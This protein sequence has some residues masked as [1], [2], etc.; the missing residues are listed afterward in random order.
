MVKSN[1][2][3]PAFAWASSIETT[4]W[5][6]PTRRLEEPALSAENFTA[7][8]PPGVSSSLIVPW[9]VTVPLLE[10]TEPEPSPEPVVVQY[11]IA[12]AASASAATTPRTAIVRFLFSTSVNTEQLLLSRFRLERGAPCEGDGEDGLGS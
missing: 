9:S 2:L 5:T 7:E 1:A 11:A 6:L 10:A 12:A 4:A 3:Q 8:L